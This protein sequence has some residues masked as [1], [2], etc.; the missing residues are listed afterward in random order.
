M[1]PLGAFFAFAVV[2][3]ALVGP[4]NARAATS[5][6]A[7]GDF[8]QSGG[9]LTGWS[10][11]SATLTLASDGFGGGHAAMAA[12]SGTAST[13]SLKSSPQP[14]SATQGTVYKADGM[15]RSDTPG[16]SVCLKIA[17]SGTLS[18]NAILCSTSTGTWV[19][20]PQVTYTAKASG[21]KLVVWVFQKAAASGNSF[22]ADNISLTTPASAAPAA[23]TNLHTTNVLS[24]DV[25]LAWDASPTVGVT[26]Y[27]V[28]RGATCV[29]QSQLT[30]VNAPTTT[31]ADT[32]TQ[33][34]TSY[35]Y[36]VEAF[37]GTNH[38]VA[39]NCV[40]VTTPPQV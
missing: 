4:L 10:R 14:V 8:E 9:S 33:P 40:S 26:S 24:N 2:A 27:T 30:S 38:S 11:T 36:T 32:T 1:I 34:S 3:M 25:D 15:V 31:F 28:Y 5:L 35:A 19:A 39:S 29:S 16:K 12:Y 23:P 13:Y 17:E 20:L 22:E 6:L 18:G 7:N 21:D 37:D